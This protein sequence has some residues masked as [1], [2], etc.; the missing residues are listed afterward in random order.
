MM[1]SPDGVN[2][3]MEH[4]GAGDETKESWNTTEA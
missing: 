1:S 2:S 4:K 3:D